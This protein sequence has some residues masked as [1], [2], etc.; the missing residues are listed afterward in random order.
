MQNTA[1]EMRISDWSSDVCSSDLH[2]RQVTS[3][4]R[5]AGAALL[6]INGNGLHALPTPIRIVVPMV[7]AAI[8]GIGSRVATRL[9]IRRVAA[10]NARITAATAPKDGPTN[11]DE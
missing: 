2:P 11:Q 6:H 5:L 4:H 8:V 7:I 9:L 1:Y 10:P 3:D